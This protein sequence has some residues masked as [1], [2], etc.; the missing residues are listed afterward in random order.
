VIEGF[1]C[2]DLALP[3]SDLIDPVSAAA[4][5]A[6]QNMGRVSVPMTRKIACA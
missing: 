3:F 2:P 5:D 4:F 1:L 6:F